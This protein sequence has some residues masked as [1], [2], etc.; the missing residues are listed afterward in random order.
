MS[1]DIIK[2]QTKDLIDQ[3]IAVLAIAEMNIRLS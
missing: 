2:Q 1:I 3:T